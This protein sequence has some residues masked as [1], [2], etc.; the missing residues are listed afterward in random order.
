MRSGDIPK[1]V[2]VT[3][4]DTGVGKTFV[5]ATLLRGFCDSGLR[6]VGM[7]P[8]AAGIEPGCAVNADVAV[9][10]EAGNVDAPLMDRNPYA[11]AAPIA[12]HLAAALEGRVIDIGVISLAYGRL[13][14]VSDAV[15]VEGA[16]GALVPLDERRDMLDIAAALGLPVL[17]VVGMRLGCLNH[18][19][20][21]ALA[22]RARGL[23]LA[24]WVANRLPPE[25]P[26][27]EANIDTLARRFGVAPIATF[28]AGMP[29]RI[30]PDRL[31]ALEM[32]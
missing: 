22:I 1:G 15:V 27:A 11:F 20:L 9:L 5:A 7:K 30:A 29:S 8:V 18:A 12:P 6:A 31:N 21:S 16:G 19:L 24:G 28:G 25:M 14:A 4:T 32:F 2:F 26:H 10:E 17:L 23:T 13:A 3:G